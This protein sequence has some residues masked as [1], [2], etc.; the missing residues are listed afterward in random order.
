[1][2]KDEVITQVAN[3][4]L[5]KLNIGQIVNVVRQF[6]M[7]QAEEYYNSLPDDQ[8]SELESRIAEAKEKAQQ[9][10]QEQESEQEAEEP[11]PA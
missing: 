1:M 4:I 11:V 6:S 9:S 3:D 7:Q 10:S 2:D 8:R 5:N